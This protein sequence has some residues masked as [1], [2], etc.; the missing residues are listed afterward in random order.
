[1]KK[2]LLLFVLASWY[3]YSL[4]G[5]PNYGAK[6]LTAASREYPR[7]T[8]LQVCREDIPMRCVNV[9]VNDFGPDEKIHPDR[10][11][12]LSKAS[13]ERL[14][15]LSRGIIKVN[16]YEKGTPKNEKGRLQL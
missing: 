8:V 3:N 4:P 6:N 11:I 15:P 12:D 7:G 16:I 10:A 13:F 2:I 1:M 14:A 5:A 9:R